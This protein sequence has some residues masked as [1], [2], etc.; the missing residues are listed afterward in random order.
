MVVSAILLAIVMVVTFAVA[1]VVGLS[2]TVRLSLRLSLIATI[3]SLALWQAMIHLADYGPYDQLLLNNLT[4]VWPPLAIMAM[5]IFIHSLRERATKRLWVAAWALAVGSALQI[6][7]VLSGTIITAVS[8]EGAGVD[9]T[10]GGGYIVFI[11]GL[12]VSFVALAVKLY[13]EYRT[14]S[15]RGAERR[16]LRMIIWTVVVAS[17]FGIVANV[18]IPI[19]FK[20]QAFIGFGALTS[21]I[22]AVGF[23]VSVLRGGLLDIRMYVIRTV[24]YVLTLATLALIYYAF[25]TLISGMIISVST[26]PITV[27]LALVLAFIFQ[28]VK[29]FFDKI[30]VRLFYRTRYDRT[31]FYGEL[32]RILAS[33]ASLRALLL[34]AATFLGDTLRAESASF[35]VRKQTGKYMTAGVSSRGKIPDADLADIVQHVAQSTPKLIVASI[36]ER[37]HLAR[38]FT[39]HGVALALPLMRA[40]EVIGFLFLGNHKSGGYTQRDIVILES[41]ADEIVIAIQNASSIQEIRDLNETLQQRIDEATKEL[42]VSNEQLRKLDEAKDEFI[43][44]ASHQLRTP[45]TSIKGYIDMMLEGDAGDITPTQRKFLTEAFVSSERMVH[46]INDFL[47]VSRL[48]TGKFMIDKRPTDLV[49]V[50]EQEL[51]SLK[52]NASG[53]DLAFRYKPDRKLPKLMLDEGKIRQVVMN[54]ADNA[55]YYSQAGTTINVTLS[56]QGDDVVLEVK[57]TGIGVPKGEQARLFTKF[58]RATNARKQRPD[59]TGVGLYLAKRVI[60]GHGGAMVFSSLEGKGSTFGFR[61]PM[62][63]LRVRDDANEL[64][65]KPD[66]D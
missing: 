51:D 28:P 24:A 8:Y 49:K 6:G 4:F 11:V 38:I 41:I 64:N 34:R 15:P 40:D 50:V 47:N 19:I 45:L 7:A 26:E 17:L 21:V 60:T 65:N 16:A 42:R 57:D 43:S 23:A 61:L 3:L 14:S 33:N 30:T 10:R 44:M 5:Y 32:S 55:L 35:Y 48:Q 9:I 36:L 25:A 22:F 58:F 31:T 37:S 56:R 2:R 13:G 52:V 54:F 29:S 59:G 18:I 39:S 20:T 66:N 27:A 53:R 62:E 1:M 46:L 12:I 63:R